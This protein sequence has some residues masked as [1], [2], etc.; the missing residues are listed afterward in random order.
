MKRNVANL[1]ATYMT[2][3]SAS[4]DNFDNNVLLVKKKSFQ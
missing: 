2:M 4:F 3:I 1:N